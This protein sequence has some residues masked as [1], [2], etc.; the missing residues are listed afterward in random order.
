MSE[1]EPL[2]KVDKQ[3]APSITINAKCSASWNRKKWAFIE[4]LAE[5]QEN[6]VPS[7]KKNKNFNVNVLRHWQ[8]YYGLERM[9]LTSKA[10]HSNSCV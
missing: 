7:K 6:V 2:D 10:A 8:G 4:G 9:K 1:N 5:G 3:H